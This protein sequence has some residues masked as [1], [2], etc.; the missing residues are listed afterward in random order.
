MSTASMREG[1]SLPALL[2]LLVVLA[3]GL[4]YALVMGH[5][6]AWV[7]VVLAVAVLALAT[8]LIYLFYRLV[9]AVER[10]AARI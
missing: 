3:L 10:I 4:V 6:F 2:G 1:V 7:M 5:P 9:V 8:F